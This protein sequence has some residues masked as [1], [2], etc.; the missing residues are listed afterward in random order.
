MRNHN[1]VEVHIKAHCD[2]IGSHK[3]NDALSL[4]RANTVKQ[5]LVS[6]KLNER[7][8]NIKALGKR[9]PLN[10]NENPKARALNRR[11]EIL[12]IARD[13]LSASKPDML[14]E[15]I[16]A[17]NDSDALWKDTATL[18]I[19]NIE[20]G[21]SFVLENMNF[22]GGRHVLLPKSNKTLKLLLN[23]LKANPALEIEIQGH[24]CCERTGDGMDIDTHTLDLSVNRAKAIYDYLVKSGI[25]PSRL[26]YRG[27]GSSR[28]LVLEFTEA[29]R[30]TNRRVEVK[31]LKK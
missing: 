1:I 6:K 29:D 14:P 5:Y 28:K 15:K 22:Y 13:T 21:K 10:K 31:V 30:T 11:A 25:D 26:S 12:F 7:I 17:R 24:I 27:F 3:Y 4:N 23:T 2:S 9:F 19:S 20:V 8:I 18:A 16:E